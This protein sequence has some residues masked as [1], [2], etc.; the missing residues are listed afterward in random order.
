MEEIRDSENEM[1]PIKFLLLQRM[2]KLKNFLYHLISGI[3]FHNEINV[4]QM[5]LDGEE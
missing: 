2:V 5:Q 3:G 1:K 4:L